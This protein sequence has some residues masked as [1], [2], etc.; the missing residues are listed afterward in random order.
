VAAV[1]EHIVQDLPIRPR[2]GPPNLAAIGWDQQEQQAKEQQ[3]SRRFA[4]ANVGMD[5]PVY[6]SPQTQRRLDAIYRASLA[7]LTPPM[8]PETKP[9]NRGE[10]VCKTAPPFVYDL[11]CSNAAPDTTQCSPDILNPC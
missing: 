9:N 6:Y 10:V 5:P 4:A 7:T 3:E 2:V 11:L 8:M 1:L